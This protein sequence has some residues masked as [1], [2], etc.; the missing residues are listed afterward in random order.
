[1][2]ERSS[3]AKVTPHA[4]LR[5]EDLERAAAFYAV[6]LGLEVAPEPEPARELRV[7]AGDGLI[8]VYERPTMP[9]PANTVACFE[10]ADVRTTVAELRERGV[11][12][13][14]YDLPEVGL[15]TVDGIAEVDGHLRAWF[16]DS[17]GNVL[18][19]AQR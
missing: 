19:I 14:E 3:L 13:E 7:R 16:T 9:A 18:V 8:C 2:I 17:E 6:V 5:A 12:F 4:V 11:E 1:M 10:V 15:V